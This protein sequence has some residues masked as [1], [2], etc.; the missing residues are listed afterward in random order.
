LSLISGSI[1]ASYCGGYYHY[2]NYSG[3][4]YDEAT[5]ECTYGESMRLLNLQSLFIDE[6][7][8]SHYN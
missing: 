8:N 6:P 5:T 7:S 2:D 1:Y 4:Y 3:S